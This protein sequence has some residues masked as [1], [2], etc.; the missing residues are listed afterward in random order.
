MA[1]DTA[2]AHG[3]VVKQMRECEGRSELVLDVTVTV[4]C[5]SSQRSASLW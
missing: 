5:S 4:T 3:T 2:L 1:P